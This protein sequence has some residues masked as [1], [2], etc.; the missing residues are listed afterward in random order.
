MSLLD[1]Y[2]ISGRSVPVRRQKSARPADSELI[3]LHKPL[4][5]GERG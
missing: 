1:I 3:S 5:Q 2:A 4:N